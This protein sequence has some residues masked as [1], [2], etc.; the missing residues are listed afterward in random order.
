MR[1]FSANSPCSWMILGVMISL[2]WIHSSRAEEEVDFGADI[3]PLLS[4][5]CYACHGPDEEHRS[6]GFRL[7]LEG[8]A[9]G[10]ADSGEHPIVPGDVD[11]S[12]IMARILSTDPDVQMPPPDS[13]KSLKPAEI[14]KI[15]QWVADGAKYE[16]HWSFQP[17]T[18]PEP[19]TVKQTDW[20]T[21]SIDS[22][23]LA[24]LEKLGLSPTDSASKERLIRRVTFDLTGLPP[25]L[26][27]VDAFLADESPDAYEKV[28]DRL[29]A[30]PHYGEHMARFWLDAARFGDTHGLHLD[31]YREMW[32][33][34]DWVIQAFNN[35]QPFDQFTIEQL[36]GD[37]LENPTEDQ[38]IASGFN[39]CHVTT[40]E[41]GS[42]KQEVETRNV[43]DR[44]TTTGTVFMGLT[45]ECT[46]CHDHK[47]D[48]LTMNDFYSMYAFFNSFDYNPMDGNVK[49][50]APTIRMVPSDDQQQIAKL[51]Q[52]IEQTKTK[53]S[54]QLAAIEYT[55]PDAATPTEDEPAV[56]VVWIDDDT[57]P[58]AKLHGNLYPWQWV[59][60]PEPV[61]AGKRSSKRTSKELDQ[62]YFTEA[63]E[64]L[65]IYED[66]VLFTYVYLDPADPPKEIM[67]QWNNGNWNFRAYWG[68]NLI[69]FGSDGTTSRQHQGDLPALGEWVRLE[70]PVSAI[71]LK[72]GEKIN[73]WAFTQWGGTVYWDQSG[74]ATRE[75]RPRVYRSLAQWST[76][77]AAKKKP[78]EPKKIV[79]IAKKEAE[80]RS[81]AEQTQLQRYFVEH[82]FA[83]TR[84]I[85]TP[86]QQT[87]AAN[88][89]TIADMTNASPTTL[90]SKEK[91]KPVTAYILER[92]EYDQQGEEIGRATPGMLP[93]MPADAPLN[94]L[95]LA[96]WLVNPEHPLT[97]RVTV[98]RLWQHAFGTGLVKTAEDFGLQGDPPSHPQLLDWLAS[99]FIADG[100][101]VKTMMKRI[102]LSST[103]RQS[104][105]M[106][107]EAI[108]RDPNNRLL[109]RGPRFRL[110][111]E[112]IRDQALAVS[113][114]LVDQ[115]GGPSVKPPQPAGLWKSVGYSGSNT[116]Q[117]KADEGHAK[118][119]RRTLYTFVKRTS[120]PPQMST[121]DAPSRE[122]CT[123]RRERTN[124]PLQALMLMNDPQFV[125]T[126]RALA[127]RTRKE[128]G[129][130]PQA[131]AAFLL[132]LCM[133]RNP[134]EQEIAEI[135]QLVSAAQAH[136]A[137]EPKAAEAL[138]NVGEIPPDASIDVAEN[139]EAAAWTL[140]AN[141]VLNLDEVITKN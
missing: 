79:A 7:D 51:Q 73:G 62:H 135:V 41:G 33:Y 103:Y 11:A 139:A 22:F 121:L 136:F 13:N 74:V 27:E 66:D 107:P 76:E 28:V 106:T 48:P 58:G 72:P 55:E 97:A 85:F 21:N 1:L 3:R 46:R 34:R 132:R 17:L 75:G 117:F 98:N 129:E 130:T 45:F 137:A 12:E 88:E 115:I 6:G 2:S 125:E 64:P 44:V 38:K 141:L 65:T 116:V 10:E 77:L 42:I 82:V 49:D 8:S 114:L 100:W 29:L 69:P 96:R 20:P 5:N 19:P 9:Y 113:G 123:V 47:Y 68:E 112:M 63:T 71:E 104:S 23:V 81:E 138:L 25:T 40:N 50:H 24:K 140:A 43:I 94:R 78:T 108:A 61:F 53:I 35:N 80:K 95:G 86:L 32:L 119:H 91:D 124:T 122:S 102:V 31:N 39:R 56:D 133:S 67:L 87:I 120:P 93:P 83:D 99:Q 109:A 26:N 30:S 89:K 134:H 92:G 90:I 36:A 14:A 37:L 118:V 57:P 70:I 111:A 54:E 128:G 60:A 4:N 126:A 16:L 52:E 131:Q 101:D 84:E 59:E 110:D 127:I 18:K 105:K 15:R